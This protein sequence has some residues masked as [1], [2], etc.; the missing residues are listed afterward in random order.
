M[1]ERRTM[2]MTVRELIEKLEESEK[3]DEIDFVEF[4][5]KGTASSYILNDIK[6]F[7]DFNI[8][9]Y[10]CYSNMISIDLLSE[11]YPEFLEVKNKNTI[12]IVKNIIDKYKDLLNKETKIEIDYDIFVYERCDISTIEKYNELKLIDFDYF[13]YDNILTLTSTLEEIEKYQ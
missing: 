4:C 3:L 12:F 2:T 9:R 10:D 1:E 11:D 8:K 5:I 6:R 13:P 7:Y